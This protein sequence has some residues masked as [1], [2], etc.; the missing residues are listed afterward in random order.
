MVAPEIIIRA[1]YR[2]GIFQNKV[3]GRIFGTKK[4]LVEERRS[5]LRKE[6]LRNFK[7]LLK[8]IRVCK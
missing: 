6:Q 1:I 2:L 5:K 7:L 4:E 3:L 8:H